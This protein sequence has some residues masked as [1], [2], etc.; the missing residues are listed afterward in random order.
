M[1]KLSTEVIKFLRHQ[2]IYL[3]GNYN[4][5]ISHPEQMKSDVLYNFGIGSSFRASTTIIYDIQFEGGHQI[6][7][8]CSSDHKKIRII[9]NSLLD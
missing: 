1:S 8:E 3:L 7:I 2:N 9:S 4:V 5:T 6:I